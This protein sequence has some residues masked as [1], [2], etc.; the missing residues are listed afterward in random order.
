YAWP[1]LDVEVRCSKGTYIRSLARNLGEALGCG[2]YVE[3]LRRTRVGP[4][5]V[6]GAV[7]LGIPPLGIHQRLRPMA[8]AVAE[9][10]R[11]DVDAETAARLRHGQFPP[12]PAGTRSGD[13][14][15]FA[16]GEL[17]AVAYLDGNR[18]RP[19][20]VIPVE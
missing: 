14:A 10:P 13:A 2:A 12:A 9:L 8:E 4:F 6:D 3:T 15:V 11:V 16:A 20:K 17:V 18:L 7:T 5:A 1:R 19:T